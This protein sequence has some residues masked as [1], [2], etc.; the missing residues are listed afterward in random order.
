[1]LLIGA[2]N[3]DLDVRFAEGRFR[4]DLLARFAA[5]RVVLPPLRDR[6]EDVWAI[7]R[8]FAPASGLA[9]EP[10]EHVEVEAVERLL[11]ERWPSNIRDLAGALARVARLEPECLGAWAVEEE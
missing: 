2:T 9:L 5:A 6:A 7:A 1:M 10:D 11:L 3:Q 4:R 8:A